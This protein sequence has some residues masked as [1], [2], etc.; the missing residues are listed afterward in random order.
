[1]SF[2]FWRSDS[3]LSTHLIGAGSPRRDRD[4]RHR[5]GSRRIRSSVALLEERALLSTPTITTVAGNH[6]VGYAGDGGP[7][8]S[9]EFFYPGR[10]AVHLHG[11]LFISDIDNDVIREVNASTGVITTVAGNGL[12]GSSGD[13]GPA[14]SAE[15]DGPEGV[16]V[17]ADGNLFIADTYNDEIREVHAGTGVIT[18]I[19]GAPPL[20]GPP[21]DGV[22]LNEPYGVAVDA[23]GNLFIANTLGYAILEVNASTR[24]ITTV[25]GNG[26]LGY[27][28]DGGP[29]TAPS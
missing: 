28:G 17:D 29:A 24:A 8:T 13:G 21:A 16:A 25:A 9:A 2:S 26:T 23:H 3:S 22:S 1:M 7:A 11:N 27:T 20:G 5:G 12:I 19:V 10:V 4:R 6:T 15:L 18:T 14:T